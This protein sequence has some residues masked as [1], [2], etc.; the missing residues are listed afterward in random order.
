MSTRIPAS[1]RCYGARSSHR[2]VK[3]SP[4]CER[5]S[6]EKIAMRKSLQFALTAGSM[7][8]FAS[9]A[10]AQDATVRLSPLFLVQP[11]VTQEYAREYAP[12]SVLPSMNWRAPVFPHTWDG[13]A[14]V[15]FTLEEMRAGDRASKP[16]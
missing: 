9:A 14:V 5:K 8:I 16:D 4:V 13:Q 12:Y 1:A 3:A 15:P 6:T 2:E 7:F 10:M 11:Q